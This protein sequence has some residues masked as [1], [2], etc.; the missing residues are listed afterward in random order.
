MKL[1]L[2]CRGVGNWRHVAAHLGF[3]E[4]EIDDFRAELLT[5]DGSPYTVM[6]HALQEKQ[7]KV[8]VA[9]FVRILQTRKIQRFDVV[10]ILEPYVYEQISSFSEE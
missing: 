1:D 3:T 2:S 5:P 4:N 6:L 8:T 10:N 9:E 7:P